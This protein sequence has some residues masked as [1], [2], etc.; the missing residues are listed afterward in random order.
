[1]NHGWLLVGILNNKKIGDGRIH[2]VG[3]RHRFAMGQICFSWE[4]ARPDYFGYAV[5]GHAV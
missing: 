2:W 4:I 1:M 5:D 3:G